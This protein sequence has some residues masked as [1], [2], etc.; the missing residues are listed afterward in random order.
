[1]EENTFVVDR[2][3]VITKLLITVEK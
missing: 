3:P 2:H 1:M